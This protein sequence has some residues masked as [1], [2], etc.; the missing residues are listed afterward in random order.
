MSVTAGTFANGSAAVVDPAPED[1]FAGVSEYESLTTGMRVLTLLLP[2]WRAG[3]A[4]A[5]TGAAC[6]FG[7]A[8]WANETYGMRNVGRAATVV[9]GPAAA[10]RSAMA[11]G[12]T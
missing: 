11:S 12:P 9:T 8:S 2:T 1:E 5:T 3:A 6:S 10:V 7:T 4:G